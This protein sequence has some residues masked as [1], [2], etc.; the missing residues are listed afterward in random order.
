MQFAYAWT[1]NGGGRE[2]R[3]VVA[4]RGRSEFEIWVLKS[5]GIVPS[6]AAIW[7]LFGWYEREMADLNGDPQ[8]ANH[9]EPYPLVLRDGVSIRENGV[10]FLQHPPT[11][12]GHHLP[13]I[14]AK[15]VQQ[16]P[17]GPIRADVFESAEFTFFYVGEHIIHY[18]PRL[19]F[20]HR[21][22]ETCFE[23]LRRTKGSSW[24]SGSPPLEPSRM[25][26]PTA[27]PWSAPR[28]AKR[29]FAPERFAF[30][31]RSWNAFTIISITSAISA[32]RRR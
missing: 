29:R 8:F 3:Y 5:A 28:A 26:S 4:L 18:K 12:G 11:D 31:W 13:A 21:G 15:D 16:L 10:E 1:P 9:P 22:M 23:G 30:S 19:F 24:R 17:F 32:I 25:R 7:P 20:K 6:L 14:E 27:R 2:I